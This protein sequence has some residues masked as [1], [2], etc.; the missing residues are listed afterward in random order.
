MIDSV[1]LCAHIC[2]YV[3]MSNSVCLCVCVCVFFCF[4]LLMLIFRSYENVKF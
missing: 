1:W 4:G 2:Q 3:C